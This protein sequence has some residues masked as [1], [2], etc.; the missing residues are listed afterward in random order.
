MLTTPKGMRLHIAIFGRRNTGKSSVLNALTGQNI[1]IVS[2]EA[3]T[4]TDPVEKAMELLPIGPV[5]FIDTAGMDDT[6]KLG[7]LRV[8]KSAKIFDRADIIM[9]VT[10]TGV[11]GPYEKQILDE[12]KKR[13]V[14]AIA[15]LNKSDITKAPASVIKELKKRKTP[16][17]Q[18][19]AG[20]KNPSTTAIIKEKLIDII[21]AEFLSP[22]PVI[23]D[24]IAKDR[25]VI[26][27]IP[28]DKEAPKGRLILPEQMVLREIL[29]KKALCMITN[30]HNL[31]EAIKNLKK[32]PDLV[33]TDSQAFEAVL[34]NTPRGIPLTSFSILLARAKGDMTEL[35]A[36]TQAV[37]KLKNG[38]SILIAEAC[39]HHPIG[40]DIGRVKIPGWLRKKTGKKLIFDVRAGRDYPEDLK[41]YDLIVHCGSCMLNRKE[42]LNRIYAARRA[43]V[44]ITNY[45]VLIAFLHG[46]LKR[47]LA[48][49]LKES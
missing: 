26:L 9:L 21:P 46:G 30:E 3:G 28:I 22:P 42:T 37:K 8:K 33:V 49:L 38:S 10:E 4:T 20:V 34:K 1:S 27:V 12:A 13:K 45:G 35:V 36:G 2:E 25:T 19:C 40:D 6:G 41:K 48:P 43:G 29:D 23:A 7:K 44:P 11:F 16:F 32:K 18:I 14:P 39:T 5:L 17:V 47:A 24:L 15:V 31:K